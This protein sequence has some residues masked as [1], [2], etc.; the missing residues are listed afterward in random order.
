MSDVERILKEGPSNRI[1]DRG[2][3][4]AAEIEETEKLLGFRFPPSY[5]EFLRLGGLDELRFSH[6]VLSPAEIVRDR[7]FLPD[8]SHVPFA[9]NGC[10]DSYCWGKS[11][12]IEPA[13]LFYDHEPRTYSLDATSFTAWLKRCRF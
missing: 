8:D 3:P 1:E 6:R 7:R 10:G 5:R 11:P 9:E 12:E 2:V 4:T 13:V